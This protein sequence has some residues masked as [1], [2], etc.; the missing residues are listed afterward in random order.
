LLEGTAKNHTKPH[1]G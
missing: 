1:S